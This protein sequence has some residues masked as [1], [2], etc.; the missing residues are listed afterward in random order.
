MSCA[1]L[2]PFFPFSYVS[3][4]FP[5][6]FFFLTHSHRLHTS[7]LHPCF[8]SFLSVS[9]SFVFLCHVFVCI[10]SFLPL[11]SFL[12]YLLHRL[13][14]LLPLRCFPSFLNLS[15]SYAALC[16]FARFLLLFLLYLSILPTSIFRP[17]HLL[18]SLVSLS[19]LSYAFLCPFSTF[20]FFFLLSFLLL[21]LPH[22]P[23][24][25]HFLP[26]FCNFCYLFR[27]FFSYFISNSSS[28]NN[29]HFLHLFVLHS[30]TP[31]LVQSFSLLTPLFSLSYSLL[32][33]ISLIYI[34]KL[35]LIVTSAEQVEDCRAATREKR[36]EKKADRHARYVLF[37]CGKRALFGPVFV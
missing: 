34:N 33:H 20:L 7:F 4:L 19:C 2:S 5:S 12:F 26:F 16:P 32:T 13:P 9:L 31:I 37:G 22:S 14:T 35:H 24:L 36:R 3:F 1:L 30:F 18:A 27:L 17:F 15:L 8:P 29:S 10:S 6:I 21:F 23:S 28:T 11:L 25:P